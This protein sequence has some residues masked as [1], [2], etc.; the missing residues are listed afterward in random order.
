MAIFAL[1]LNQKK[2]PQSRHSPTPHQHTA[3]PATNP[4]ST[5]ASPPPST[6]HPSASLYL[7]SRYALLLS[8][9][10]E[11]V[12]YTYT[13]SL[14]SE[15]P[16]DAPINVTNPS[17]KKTIEAI[18]IGQ[19]KTCFEDDIQLTTAGLVALAP[20]KCRFNLGVLLG[21]RERERKIS[22]LICCVGLDGKATKA[23]KM[24]K[25]TFD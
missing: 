6:I 16:C 5:P 11:A 3:T 23:P 20:G 14:S 9:P 15:S 25:W 8:C 17:T 24:V 7:S 4:S 19:C 22:R 18:V 10:A 1:M 12:T 21:G 2:N 13:S